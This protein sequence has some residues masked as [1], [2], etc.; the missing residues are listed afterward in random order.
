MI[1]CA[2]EREGARA[3]D[4]CNA[5]KRQRRDRAE[6]RP[7]PRRSDRCIPPRRAG[8]DPRRS[9][10][11]A[12]GRR[13][14]CN[15]GQLAPAAR[16]LGG[17]GACRADP[18]ARRGARPGIARGIVWCVDHLGFVRHAGR[19]DP[20]SRRSR[21]LARGR[22]ARVRAGTARRQGRRTRGRRF[23]EAGSAPAGSPGGS[24]RS[25]RS[26]TLRPAQGPRRYR[27]QDGIQ[28]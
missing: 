26:R 7:Q 14:A 24:P 8:V 13:R 17:S 1:T 4:S 11:R 21:R 20:Q 12:R 19:G 10:Q 28:P 3:K 27:C 22:A 2:R 16:D 23:G 5:A 9:D 15:R 25:G 18:P 6:H